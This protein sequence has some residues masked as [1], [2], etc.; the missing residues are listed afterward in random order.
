MDVPEVDELYGLPLRD[1]VPA[2]D[3]LAKSLRAEGRREEASAVAALRRPSVA[4]WVVNQLMRT[5]RRAAAE[6]LDSGAALLDTQGEV[7][8][9][10]GSAA[11]LRAASERHRHAVDAL[12]A[13]AGGLLDERGRPPSNPTLERVGETLH[14]ISLDPDLRDEAT[15]GRLLD[16]HRYIGLGPIGAATPAPGA[17]RAK[18]KA[19]SQRRPDADRE[20]E[21]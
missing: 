11:D 9:R 4:A 12:R 21:A 7:L 19:K 10:R 15:A 14:A 3:A 13:Q 8:A 17:A 16:A 1:F 2:R 20:E 18:P 5:Q 6:L